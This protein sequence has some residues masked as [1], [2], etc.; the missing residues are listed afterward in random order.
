MK[1][2]VAFAKKAIAFARSPQGKRDYTLAVAAVSS[3][4]GILKQ[5]GVI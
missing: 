1:N 3:V 4:A 2:A 5:F